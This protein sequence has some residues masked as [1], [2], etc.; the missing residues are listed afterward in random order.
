M[1]EYG[2]FHQRNLTALIIVGIN[3][4]ECYATL[5]ASEFL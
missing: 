3:M 1:A 4:I 5:L 2:G